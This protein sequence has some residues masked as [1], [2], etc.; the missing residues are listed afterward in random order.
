MWFTDYF[1]KIKPKDKVSNLLKI[2][3]VT[4]KFKV[5]LILLAM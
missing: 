4:T 3:S 2:S 1:K 5:Q